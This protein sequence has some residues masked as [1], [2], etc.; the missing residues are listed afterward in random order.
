MLKDPEP[1]VRMYGTFGAAN[2][3]NSGF[4]DP[5]MTLLHDEYEEV[6]QAAARTL[7]RHPEEVSK[8][9]PIFL[10]MLREERPETQL[11][12]LRL[13]RDLDIKVP[14]EDLLSLLKVPRMDVAGLAC[15]QLRRESITCEEALPLL[16]NTAWSPRL[17]GLA[18]LRQNAN[19]QSVEF[20]LPLL[21]DPEE[22][23]RA[24]A[25]RLLQQLTGQD[26]S[27]DQSEKWEQWWTE[28]KATFTPKPLPSR[29]RPIELER[30][31]PASAPPR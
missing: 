4:V 21:K 14:R 5:L 22:A 20:A 27:P 24:R 3:W 26:I 25:N 16:H 23:V 2:C 12:A 18:I 9:A 7:G 30:L 17:M 10:R 6:S 13:L 15:Q 19:K 31:P 28:N 8:H 11:A 29:S 1:E